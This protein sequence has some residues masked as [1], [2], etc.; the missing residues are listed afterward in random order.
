MSSILDALRKLE[1]EKAAANQPAEVDL[2]EETAERDLVGPSALHRGVTLRLTP[3]RL[4]FIGLVFVAL[5][6]AVSIGAS[7]LVARSGP[8]SSYP[9][10]APQ[11]Q[12][13][14]PRSGNQSAA[15]GAGQQDDRDPIEAVH[16]PTAT[17]TPPP[18]PTRAEA[19]LTD[20]TLDVT[21]IAQAR[22]PGL[23]REAAGPARSVEAETLGASNPSD[24]AP[25]S[26]RDY[27]TWAMD[28]PGPNK[29][30]RAGWWSWEMAT[31]SSS[32]LAPAQRSGCRP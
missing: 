9:A 4:V 19:S 12:M 8:L 17:P 23:I 31:S 2:D 11:N 16:T 1:E 15:P 32:I 28:A 13:V 21:A 27:D 24:P 29:P 14:E 5:V 26:R 10:D 20:P 30:P 18:R 22:T 3:G 7:L 25:A 6:A